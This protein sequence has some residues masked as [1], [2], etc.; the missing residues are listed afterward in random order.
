MFGPVRSEEQRRQFRGQL[1]H[2]LEIGLDR[3]GEVVGEGDRVLQD[4]LTFCVAKDV[5]GGQDRVAERGALIAE[6]RE[7]R[8]RI[9]LEGLVQSVECRRSRLCEGSARPRIGAGHPIDILLNQSVLTGLEASGSAAAGQWF[10]EAAMFVPIAKCPA[11]APGTE[12][13][14]GPVIPALLEQSSQ[15]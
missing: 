15:I 14:T 13:L 9:A 4:C 6:R 1:R 10:D 11:I 7:R 12:V 2:T 8:E 5:H 3:P